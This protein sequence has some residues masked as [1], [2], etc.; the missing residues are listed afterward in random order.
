[1][2]GLCGK[3]FGQLEKVNKNA[4]KRMRFFCDIAFRLAIFEVV[5]SAEIALSHYASI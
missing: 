5:G 3:H 1:M 2:K 4:N